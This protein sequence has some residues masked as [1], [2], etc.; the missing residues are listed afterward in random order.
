MKKI[1]YIFMITLVSLVLI[2]CDNKEEPNHQFSTFDPPKFE[3]LKEQQE[4]IK[5]QEDIEKFWEEYDRLNRLSKYEVKID[6]YLKKEFIECFQK[7]S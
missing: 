5:Q 3:L 2:S 4:A 7:H 1:V 6:Q